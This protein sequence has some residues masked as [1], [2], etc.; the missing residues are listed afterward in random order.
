MG[1]NKIA[2]KAVTWSKS[3]FTLH[4][5]MSRNIQRI[6]Q[7]AFPEFL[8]KWFHSPYSVIAFFGGL[9]LRFV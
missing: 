2:L 3:V 6:P 5:L 4:I 8:L 9:Y 7:I 1:G